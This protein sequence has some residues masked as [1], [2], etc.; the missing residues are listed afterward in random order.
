MV[1]PF[2]LA[3]F[4]GYDAHRAVF[5][6]IVALADEARGDSTG[7]V[8]GQGDMPVVV[9]TGAFNQTAQKTVE[10]PQLPFF[11]KD[12]LFSC[13]GAEAD[14]HGLAVQQTTVIHQLQFLDEVI[15]VPGMQVVQVL[16]VVARCVQ[17]Q[18]PSTAAVHELG[19]FPF[20]GT[21]AD[22]QWS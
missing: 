11:D 13:R 16:L 6:S 15:N 4:A 18:V 8:L 7:A 21:E 20:R 5:P 2:M 1:L 3:G 17:R 12:V 14:F 10:I 22:S 19:R 9:P